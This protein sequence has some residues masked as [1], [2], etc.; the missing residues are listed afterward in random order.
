M[1]N[2]N[3]NLSFITLSPDYPHDF[4]HHIIKTIGNKKEVLSDKQ[5]I[6]LEFKKKYPDEL[7]EQRFFEVAYDKG[8]VGDFINAMSKPNWSKRVCVEK[9]FRLLN[10]VFNEKE[11]VI[12]IESFMFI[13]EYKFTME[14]ERKKNVTDKERTDFHNK[15]KLSKESKYDKT[16]IFDKEDKK[17]NN[18]EISDGFVHKKLLDNRE[19]VSSNID[20]NLKM[21]ENSIRIYE[22]EV[23]EK[24][25]DVKNSDWLQYN[26]ELIEEDVKKDEIIQPIDIVKAEQAKFYNKMNIQEKRVLK[27]AIKGNAVSQYEMGEYYS[28][29]DTNHT[30]YREAVKWYYTSASNGYEKAFFEIGKI[31]DQFLVEY[32]GKKEALKIYTNMAKRGFPSAQC[33]LGMKY[34][35]GDGVEID[36]N[37]AILWMQKAADQKHETAICNLGDIY[38][39]IN[40]DEKAKK[41]YKI[42][43]LQG[44][45]YCKRRL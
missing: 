23:V 20:V 42:G 37:Q 3:E 5:K 45:D 22:N 13:F 43:A 31:C 2:R 44:I 30:D 8:V 11:S 15:N 9:S 19:S 33:V 29:K 41:W 26:N 24:D 7:K 21:S 12:I 35:F 39:S 17:N 34:W 1:E 6:I 18:K 28:K 36:M 4:L 27:K 16:S 10:D 25:N 32:G 38:M 14:I 40:E